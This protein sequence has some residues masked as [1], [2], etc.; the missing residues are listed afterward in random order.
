MGRYSDAA[1]DRVRA[2]RVLAH[3]EVEAC[4]EDLAF[5]AVLQAYAG[6][7]SDARARTCLMSLVAYH[8]LRISLP[9]GMPPSGRQVPELGDAVE[10]AKN[11]YCTYLR[12]YNHGVRESNVLAILVPIGFRLGD[13]DNTW[14]ATID[15][16]GN[17]RGETAH[18]SAIKPLTQPDPVAELA[19]VNQVVAGLAPID[20]RLRELGSARAG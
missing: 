18:R 2:F 20:V 3:A 19:A 7:T 5:D 8:E 13:I 15:S 12:A 1:Y 11:W 16:F 10:A 9:K 14:L 17:E 4:L 6:W